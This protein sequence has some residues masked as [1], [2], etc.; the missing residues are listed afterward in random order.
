MAQKKPAWELF[1]V[2]AFDFRRFEQL[3]RIA[4]SFQKKGLDLTQSECN[5]LAVHWPCEGRYL[6]RNSLVRPSN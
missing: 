1:S 6:N 4:R 3:E 2:R 5:S